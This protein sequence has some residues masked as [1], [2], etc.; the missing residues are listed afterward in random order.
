MLVRACARCSAE[1]PVLEGQ[2]VAGPL[3]A[4]QGRA[5]EASGHQRALGRVGGGIGLRGGAAA[6]AAQR[7][8][9]DV[10]GE[11]DRHRERHGQ[12]DHQEQRGR[13]RC[14]CGPGSTGA[15]RAPAT[16]P[17]ANAD[18]S[19]T[20]STV[21]RGSRGG[22]PLAATATPTRPAASQRTAPPAGRPAERTER[23]A[24]PPPTGGGRGAGPVRP[25]RSTASVPC[26]KAEPARTRKPPIRR[27]RAVPVPSEQVPADGQH[28]A[29]DRH[30]EQRDLGGELEEGGGGGHAMARG[31]HGLLYPS[32][33]RASDVR[34]GPDQPSGRSR[35]SA[36][37]PIRSSARSASSRSSTPDHL[38]R[39]RRR[40]GP[41]PPRPGGRGRGWRP[42]RG[43]RPPS[44]RPP[45]PAATWPSGADLPGDRHP[46]TAGDRAR[47]QAVEDTEG[48]GQTGRG[49]PTSRESIF[50]S[51][52]KSYARRDVHA[53]DGLVGA[54]PG[55]RAP[56]P[57]RGA[58]VGRRPCRSACAPR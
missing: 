43:R 26:A 7:L 2:E 11:H 46:L 56:P 39:V 32:A 17:R 38:H 51:I 28:E 42:P 54:R 15:R 44:G 23:R 58:P 57:R 37:P 4:G 25:T 47:G 20:T 5:D 40:A 35:S 50:T 41:A 12:D 36:L 30:E 19:S 16:A 21:A 49:P 24:A 34:A 27:P 14:R 52:G 33:P 8:V 48:P 18:A 13:A 55:G 3:A 45:R 1:V 9:L 6:V 22:P 29:G 10:P 53:D 31:E